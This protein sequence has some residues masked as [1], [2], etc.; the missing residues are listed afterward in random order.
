MKKVLYL[1]FVILV[2]FTNPIKLKK[3]K[4][5]LDSYSIL[6]VYFNEISNQTKGKNKWNQ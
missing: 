1:G 5:M 4:I 2:G 3:R 6:S